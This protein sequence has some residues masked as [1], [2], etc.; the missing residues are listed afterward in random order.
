MQKSAD[1]SMNGP[2]TP[3]N[4]PFILQ[5]ADPFVCRGEDGTWYFTASYPDYD[6][7]LPRIA[8]TLLGLR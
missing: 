5:R 3:Y 8:P 1:M 4:D 6:R 2:I 7:M